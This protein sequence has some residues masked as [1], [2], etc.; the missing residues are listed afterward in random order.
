MV[1]QTG[2]ALH[3]QYARSLAAVERQIAKTTA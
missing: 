1:L 2:I 3:Q